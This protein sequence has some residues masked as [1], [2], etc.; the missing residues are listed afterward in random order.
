MDFMRRG[1]GWR[2][3]D[4]TTR[5][6]VKRE[7]ERNVVGEGSRRQKGRQSVAR[8]GGSCKCYTGF[9]LNRV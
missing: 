1:Q 7:E 9:Y 4:E 2:F 6:E 8:V 3:F 5:V